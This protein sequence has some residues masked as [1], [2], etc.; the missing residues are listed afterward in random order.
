MIFGY[1]LGQAGIRSGIP[2]STGMWWPELVLHQVRLTFTV[3]CNASFTFT[4]W[5]N[6]LRC[7]PNISRT[8]WWPRMVLT[9]VQLTLAHVLLSAID[10]LEFSR[11]LCNSASA[12]F[13]CNPQ[14]PL[15]TTNTPVG[16]LTPPPQ[17]MHLVVKSH[18]TAGQHKM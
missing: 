3:R 17:Y 5:C 14:Y 9:L 16:P 8:I 18:T 12:Y 11:V 15:D 10:H 1:P 4:V 2:P 13:I 6:Q 7:I